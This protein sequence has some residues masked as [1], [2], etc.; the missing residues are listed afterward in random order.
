MPK[1]KESLFFAGL[2]NGITVC[3]RNKEEHGDYKQIAHISAQRVV[4]Y[5][6]INVSQE[7][8]EIIENYAATA[9]PPISSSQQDQFVFCVPPKNTI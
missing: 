4:S 3:D 9:N 6:A 5:W 2:G 1:M 8:K 7:A